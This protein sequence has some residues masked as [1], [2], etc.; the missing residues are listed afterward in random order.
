M[1]KK[2]IIF[3]LIFVSMLKADG[4]DA[5]GYWRFSS[6]G[7]LAIIGSMKV[8]EETIEWGTFNSTSYNEIG[9]IQEKYPCK[10]KYTIS[11]HKTHIYKLVFDTIDCAYEEMSN[12]HI[13][14]N[15]DNFSIKL[16]GGSEAI[17]SN[18]NDEGNLAFEGRMHRCDKNGNL[19]DLYNLKNKVY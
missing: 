15:F 18:Y 19:I 12:G 14:E 3:I 9:K 11:I 8:S 7:G 17:L 6:S 1:M 5:I 13:N 10:A 4:N 16:M 2:I